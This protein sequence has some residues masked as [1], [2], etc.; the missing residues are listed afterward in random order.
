MKSQVAEWVWRLAV[1]AG[2]AW[3]GLQLDRLHEDITQPLDDQASV[4][5]AAESPDDDDAERDDGYRRI[6]H[7][8]VAPRQLA[9]QPG[10]GQRS[11]HA[12][13]R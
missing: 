3:I 4:A 7:I 5:A 2:L 12:G 10:A 8:A 13:D 1:L 9:S 11:A 6:S